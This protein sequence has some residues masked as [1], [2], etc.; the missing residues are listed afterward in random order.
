MDI[1]TGI[2][3]AGFWM[4]AAN[5]IWRPEI[6]PLGVLIIIGVAIFMTYEVI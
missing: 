6:S 5:T 3:V 4:F 1:G 2:A